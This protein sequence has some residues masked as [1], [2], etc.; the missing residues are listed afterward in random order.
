MLFTDISWS[1]KYHT[2]SNRALNAYLNG[3]Q[4]YEFLYYSSAEKLLKDAISIDKNFYEAHFL[5][6]EM[7]TAIRRFSESATH[8]RHAVKIDSLYNTEVYYKLA[9]AEMMAGEYSDAL[10]HFRQYLESDKNV[11]EKNRLA[12]EKN[13]INC[14]FA[15]EA[16][17]NPVPY[18]PVNLGDSVNSNDDE[19]WPSIT[20]D[21]Q[22]LMFTRQTRDSRVRNH[23]DFYLSRSDGKRWMIA[24]NAGKPLNTT[25]NEGAQSLSSDGRYMYFTACD[26][27]GN[28]GSCDI[29]FSA[30]NGKTWSQPTN[31]Q[32]PVNTQYWE[33]QP[34]VT[35]DGRML[36]FCSNRPGGF[37]GKDIWYSVINSAGRWK[38]PV[39]MGR[40]VNT[41]G[42]EVSPFIHFD[43]KTLYFST[44]GRTGMGGSDIFM[45]RMNE[46]STWS[47]P[48]NLGYPINTASDEMGLIIESSGRKAYFSTV[49][50]KAFGKDI[51]SFDLYD[52]IRPA[53]VAYLNGRVVNK[54]NGAPVQA[55]YELINLSTKKLTVNASTDSRGNFLVCLP[56]GYNYGLNVSRKGFLF[57]S[58]NFMFEGEHS[59]R[60]PLNKKIELT[61][62]KVGEKMQLS[63][64]FYEFDS[65]QL[66][67]ESLIELDLLVRMLTDNPGI[68]IEVGGYTDSTGSD[69]YNLTLSE[70]R[71]LSVVDYLRSKGIDQGRLV[72]KG[73]GN[74]SPLADNENDEGRRLNRRTEVKIIGSQDL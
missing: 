74:S 44:D 10:I 20:A 8:Y 24:Q 50:D 35:A 56:S 11:S 60:E 4:Q 64:V 67:Q 68:I 52:S 28:I 13:I 42:D 51:F 53:P 30:Y 15:A 43:G 66:R 16:V 59:A 70:K 65:W 54:T 17:K 69:E 2:S 32:R 37:G 47:E 71:A 62:V 27:R 29:Y 19:Y 55:D 25:Q 46:D 12:V 41:A 57:Y 34:S 3:K 22:V 6:G 61:S 63:N 40:I 48:K 9:N 39:N 7:F 18:N 31:L 26:R 73:Y 5:L 1:Q 21:G 72:H 38:E 33:S 49:R 23:E 45:A 14:Q 36:F 58:E